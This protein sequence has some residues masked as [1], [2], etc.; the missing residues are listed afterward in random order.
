MVD[1]SQILS[2][3]I[4][5]LILC[6]KAQSFKWFYLGDYVTDEEYN[7]KKLCYSK[8]CLLDADRIISAA[9]L[10]SSVNPCDDFKSFAA[11]EFFK[12]RVP[13]DSYGFNGFQNDVRRAFKEKQRAVLKEPVRPDEPRMFKV[14]KKYFQQCTDLGRR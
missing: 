14:L 9:S 5:F 12:Y 11:G 7:N 13:N 10:S 1:T 2:C 3:A 6:Q 4:L 8:Y